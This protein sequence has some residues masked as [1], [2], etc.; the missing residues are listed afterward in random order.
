MPTALNIVSIS[1]DRWDAFEDNHLFCTE[2]SNAKM[3]MALLQ[4]EKNKKTEDEKG[5]RKQNEGERE[6]K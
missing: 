1:Q 3:L 4:V 2:N 5:R 6:E